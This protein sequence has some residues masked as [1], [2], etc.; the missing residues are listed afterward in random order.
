VIRI[1]SNGPWFA[2]GARSIG[3]M[4]PARN[5]RR[6]PLRSSEEPSLQSPVWRQARADRFFGGR[7]PRRYR[8][9]ARPLPSND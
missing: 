3:P 9:C 4:K 6:Q 2:S 1:P 7:G 5:R 8:A